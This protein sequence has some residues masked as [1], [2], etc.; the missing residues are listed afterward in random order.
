MIEVD[1]GDDRNIGIE[2]VDRIET[3]A[4]T[5]FEHCNIDRAARKQV[6]RGERRVFEKGQ[7]NVAAN[8][9]DALECRDDLG[10]RRLDAIDDDALVE[11]KQV[12]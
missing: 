3:T 1:R 9:V 2:H 7:R 6:D 4:E 8:H 5:D 11:A 12:R 10:I